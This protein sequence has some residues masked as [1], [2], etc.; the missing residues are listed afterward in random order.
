MNESRRNSTAFF[1]LGVLGLLTGIVFW[2][3][4]GRASATVTFACSAV[5][6]ATAWFFERTSRH[7]DGDRNGPNGPGRTS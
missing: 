5:V 4:S 7:D 6:F 2:A 1:F 3:T